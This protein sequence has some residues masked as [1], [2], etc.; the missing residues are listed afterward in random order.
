M[1][2]KAMSAAILPNAGK[3][4]TLTL[5]NTECNGS[6]SLELS[7]IGNLL[8][9]DSTFNRPV[10]LSQ[11]KAGNLDLKRVDFER[12]LACNEV[13]ITSGITLRSV[14][15][16]VAPD[17][18]DMKLTAE[19]K[20]NSD[21][22]TFRLIKHSFEAVANRIEA[23]H[24]FGLEME[25]YRKEL[26]QSH[27]LCSRERLLVE[28]NHIISRH[29]QSYSRPFFWLVLASLVNVAFIKSSVWSLPEFLT[30]SVVYQ[31]LVGAASALNTFAQG[32][33]VFSV[34]MRE[35]M[36]FASLAF[37]LLM[38]TFVW[39]FLVAVRRFTRG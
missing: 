14:R 6:F 29:G 35:G 26:K 17:F 16:A 15:H 1:A 18:V 13:T 22:E 36:E 8:F 11:M 28:A 21:R 20:A 4:G 19:A 9:S 25:A 38:S 5:M 24:F 23:N 12:V 27:R 39:H 3:A 34:L 30:S 32:F 33:S 7:E 2:W 37:A 10:N 31:C